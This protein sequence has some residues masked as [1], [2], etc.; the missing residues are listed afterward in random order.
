MTEEGKRVD[1]HTHHRIFTCHFQFTLRENAVRLTHISFFLPL[2]FTYSFLAQS[3][4][5]FHTHPHLFC[6]HQFRCK[7]WPGAFLINC[8]QIQA[9]QNS[10]IP[11]FLLLRAKKA[12]TCTQKIWK[13]TDRK[14]RFK[15]CMKG[16]QT[17]AYT[18][19]HMYS[20]Y[21]YDCGTHRDAPTHW[22]Q[23][24]TDRHSV[25]WK[26]WQIDGSVLIM[27]RITVFCGPFGR[28]AMDTCILYC[29]QILQAVCQ[30]HTSSSSLLWQRITFTKL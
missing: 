20:T 4:S 19:T 30:R 22:M 27:I 11:L 6:S 26:T 10:T 18:R 8:F 7:I 29:A 16:D 21:K 2:L 9:I 14:E 23:S 1:R 3:H 28:L 25:W 24:Q 15:I 17:R 13:Y 5:Q 12:H